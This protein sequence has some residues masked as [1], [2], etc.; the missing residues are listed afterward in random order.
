MEDPFLQNLYKPGLDASEIVQTRKCP[1][2][3]LLLSSRIFICPNDGTV[4]TDTSQLGERLSLNY[5]IMQEIGSGGAGIVYKA[6]HLALKKLV[7]IK[8]LHTSRLNETTLRRFEQEAKVVSS[9]DHPSIVRM[10]DYGITE[11]G[12]PYM[13]LDFIEGETLEQALQWHGS[14]PVNDCIDIFLQ[15]CDALDH[16]HKRSVASRHKAKQHHVD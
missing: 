13:V 5:D 15:I 9:L 12:Q 16:A 8:T 7:A 10:L 4:L 2:C 6:V 1:K 11:L 3:G 14:L